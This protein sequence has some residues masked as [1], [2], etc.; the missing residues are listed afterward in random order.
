MK[1]ENLSSYELIRV[2]LPLSEDYKPG[3]SSVSFWSDRMK[4]YH[5]RDV[6][7]YLSSRFIKNITRNISLRGHVATALR[8]SKFMNYLPILQSRCRYET[9]RQDTKKQ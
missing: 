2:Q 4:R 5:T 3:I 9:R 8:D 7:K 1:R 6:N